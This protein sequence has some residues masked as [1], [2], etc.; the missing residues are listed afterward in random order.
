MTDE[1]AVTAANR[2]ADRVE[3]LSKRIGELH[4]AWE[5]EKASAHR[6]RWVT[7]V[8]VVLVLAVAGLAW[9]NR[10]TAHTVAAQTQTAKQ[11]AACVRAYAN[12]NA[13]RT[14]VLTP[15]ASARSDALDDWIRA[16]PDTAPQT[17][18]ERAAALRTYTVKRLAYLKASDAYSA[19]VQDNPPPLAP[20]FSC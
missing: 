19:A 20:K 3:A 8:L 1:D 18:A 17:P 13:D 6:W 16:T 14:N 11:L 4:D 9:N 15:L 2:L 10:S 5:S 7:V 12:A